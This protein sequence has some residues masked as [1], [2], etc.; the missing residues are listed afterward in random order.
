MKMKTVLCL[1]FVVAFAVADFG[2]PEGKI[3]DGGPDDFEIVDG[4]QG[5]GESEIENQTKEIDL[6][7]SENG[8][9]EGTDVTKPSLDEVLQRRFARQTRPFGVNVGRGWRLGVGKVP[10]AG[11]YGPSLSRRL[12]RGRLTLGTGYNSFNHLRNGFRRPNVGIGYRINF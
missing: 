3:P 5:T 8:E 2:L 9:D 1:V 12:G 4:G 7:Q 6:E 10:A 11:G